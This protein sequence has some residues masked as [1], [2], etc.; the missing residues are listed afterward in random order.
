MSAAN[1]GKALAFRLCETQSTEAA[2]RPLPQGKGA[3]GS[4]VRGSAQLEPRTADPT[5]TWRHIAIADKNGRPIISGRDR[6]AE[7]GTSERA[8]GERAR[9][10]GVASLRACAAMPEDRPPHHAAGRERAPVPFTWP[11]GEAARRARGGR[12]GQRP[13]RPTPPGF[14]AHLGAGARVSAGERCKILITCDLGRLDL[15]IRR[16][17]CCT[18]FFHQKILS[19]KSMRFR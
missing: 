5:A 17:Y 4:A 8:Q 1:I 3:V 6:C 16:R 13:P 14:D 11:Q 12:I 10:G 7:R 15:E 18:A 2:E 9:S 19:G